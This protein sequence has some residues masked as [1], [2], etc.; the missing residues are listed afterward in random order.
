[1]ECSDEL[2]QALLGCPHPLCTHAYKLYWPSTHA[3]RPHYGH[4][5][6]RK[7]HIGGGKW[8]EPNAEW[9]HY[10]GIGFCKITPEARVRPLRRE[11]WSLLDIQVTAA[12]EGRWHIHWPSVEHYHR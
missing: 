11:H 6:G 2:I 4:S 8:V 12:T 3:M 9:A 10:S 7:A 5:V 1:M